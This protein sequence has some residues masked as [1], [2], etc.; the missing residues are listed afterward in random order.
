MNTETATT[1]RTFNVRTG[2]GVVH[3][4]TEGRT[5]TQRGERSTNRRDSM[6]GRADCGAQTSSAASLT[7]AAVTC[8]KCEAAR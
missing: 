6:I 8:P 2:S 1:G 4:L 7:D 3:S 5:Y